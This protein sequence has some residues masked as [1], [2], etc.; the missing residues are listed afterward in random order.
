MNNWLGPTHVKFCILNQTQHREIL[1]RKNETR[2]NKLR[3]IVNLK[4]P[5]HGNL[6]N[7]ESCHQFCYAC[8]LP[9]IVEKYYSSL[10]Q[11]LTPLLFP[12]SGTGF[13]ELKSRWIMVPY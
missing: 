11:N 13:T 5:A 8:K 10:V 2:D 3:N 9:A 4:H 12:S 1:E 6:P 7:S